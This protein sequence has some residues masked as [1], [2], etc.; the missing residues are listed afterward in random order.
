MADKQL[1]FKVPRSEFVLETFRCGGKGGQNVN[2]RETG[3]RIK[4]SESGA[5]GESQEERSQ[6]QNR[7]IA[8]ER[9]VGSKKFQLWVKMKAA[10]LDQ[11]YRSIEEKVDKSLNDE[12]L[13]IEH[14][15]TYGCDAPGCS[16]RAQVACSGSAVSTA[17]FP[18]PT[19]WL[20]VGMLSHVCSERCKKNW[21]KANVAW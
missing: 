2:K 11:G 3:V 15:V 5:V 12:N 7:K 19:G 1:L 21:E 16:K 6:A 17:T 18:L 9:L 8:F 14:L 10:A 20:Y 13:I 4:H